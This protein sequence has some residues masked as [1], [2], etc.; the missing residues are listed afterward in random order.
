MPNFAGETRKITSTCDHG[1]LSRAATCGSADFRDMA[2]STIE[3]VNC[4]FVI[5]VSYVRYALFYAFVHKHLIFVVSWLCRIATGTCASSKVGFHEN[6][7][8]DCLNFNLSYTL[9]KLKLSVLWRVDWCHNMWGKRLLGPTQRPFRRHFWV[10]FRC[11][12]A[13]RSSAG[14]VFSVLFL[15]IVFILYVV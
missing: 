3:L 1:G 13:L 6:R 12:M 9:C 2:G 15:Y 8:F 14:G 7:C 4:W 11:L 5:L 10:T